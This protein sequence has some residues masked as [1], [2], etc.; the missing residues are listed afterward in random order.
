MKRLSLIV[1]LILSATAM[2][3]SPIQ[4]REEPKP[5]P[6]AAPAAAPT[7][8]PAPLTEAAFFEPRVIKVAVSPD[9]PFVVKNGNDW[10]GYDIELWNSIAK[11]NNW[12]TEFVPVSFDQIFETVSTGKADVAL[13]NISITEDRQKQVDFSQPYMETGLGILILGE[14]SIASNRLFFPV[15]LGGGM[16]VLIVGLLIIDKRKNELVFSA[17]MLIA[18]ILCGIW[19]INASHDE[20]NS[21]N[22]LAYKKIGVVKDTTAV[23]AVDD[24]KGQSVPFETVAAACDALKSGQ[25]QAVVADSPELMH[26]AVKHPGFRTEGPIFDLQNYG[27]ALHDGSDLRMPINKALLHF[28]T[29]PEYVALCSKY[30]GNN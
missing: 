5:V 15:L 23:D 7:A 13:S 28:R 11:A 3:Q 18:V 2:A 19:G 24:Y 6:V 20:I 30:F 10:A 29:T 8:N 12:K 16:L 4:P 22:W 27:I 26:F 21:A 1:S 17:I 25:V 9:E 14:K